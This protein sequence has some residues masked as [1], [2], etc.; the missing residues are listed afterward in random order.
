MR[1]GRVFLK[2]I[3]KSVGGTAILAAILAA[4]L[5]A[6]L[7]GLLATQTVEAAPRP[8]PGA[9]GPEV[10]E[11]LVLTA[12]RT[13]FRGFPSRPGKFLTGRVAPNLALLNRLYSK[14]G[15]DY[16]ARFFIICRPNQA[17]TNQVGELKERAR[18]RNRLL[19]GLTPREPLPGLRG[20]YYMSLRYHRGRRVHSIDAYLA[21]RDWEYRVSIIPG[22]P[23][24]PGKPRS[25]SCARTGKK[26]HCRILL[27]DMRVLLAGMKAER[28]IVPAITEK[29]FRARVLLLQIGAGALIVG[30]FAGLFFARRR[31]LR[32]RREAARRAEKKR[33][34][35][36]KK[37]K[38]RKEK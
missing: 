9:S 11:E 2:K 6:F 4:F 29:S 10:G 34:K 32:L 27:E 22:G 1:N 5:A 15:R 14:N 23:A 24:R 28:K 33:R 31:R 21:D 30:L 25:D 35:E 36:K 16:R 3:S 20:A 18:N 8:R 17:R 26:E 12:C 13:S 7:A 38:D 19:R 37:R